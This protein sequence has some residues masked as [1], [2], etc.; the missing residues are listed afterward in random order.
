MQTLR[1]GKYMTAADRSLI[2]STLEVRKSIR[3]PATENATGSRLYRMRRVT[4]CAVETM[5][6]VSVMAAL[7]RFPRVNFLDDLFTVI[8]DYMAVS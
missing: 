4:M 6:I 2:S 3:I 1:M 5:Y 8:R 7:A